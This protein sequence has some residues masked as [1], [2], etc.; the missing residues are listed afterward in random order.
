MTISVSITT[1]NREIC[2]CVSGKKIVPQ[3]RGA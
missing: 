1:G 3:E 2:V